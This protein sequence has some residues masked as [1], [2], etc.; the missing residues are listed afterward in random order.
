MFY[1]DFLF[2][3]RGP[4]AKV[5]QLSHLSKKLTRRDLAS[6]D[7][8]QSVQHIE[9]PSAPLALRAQGQLLLGLVRIYD[10]QVRFLQQDCTEAQTKLD[11]MAE[12]GGGRGRGVE[13]GAEQ[14]MASSA[15]ITVS[16]RAMLDGMDPFDALEEQRYLEQLNL[17]SSQQPLDA[18][19]LSQS[20][21]LSQS[22]S[23]RFSQQARPEDISMP[24]ELPRDRPSM[25]SQFDLEELQGEGMGMS[26]E[27]AMDDMGGVSGAGFGDIS[28][29]GAGME[30]EGAGMDLGLDDVKDISGMLDERKE[31][32]GE[33]RDAD[34]VGRPRVVLTEGD[35]RLMRER[36]ERRRER[37][38]LRFAV[39][40]RD[41]D[42]ELDDATMRA[43]IRDTADIVE[44]RAGKSLVD[45]RRRR[46]RLL[47]E[48]RFMH[49]SMAGPMRERSLDALMAELFSVEGLR[50]P[51]SEGARE[52]ERAA[53]AEDEYIDAQQLAGDDF[54]LDMS[55]AGA[56][57]L[58]PPATPNRAAADESM[59]G[60]EV[61]P[62]PASLSA[63]E[64]R[65]VERSEHEAAD[66]AHD[67][68]GEDDEYTEER[69]E[70]EVA[71]HGYSDRGR[72]VLQLLAERYRQPRTERVA[73]D[74]LLPGGGGAQQ[75]LAARMFYQ[76]L[77][78]SQHEAVQCEQAEM[79]GEIQVA[80]G[81]R[82]DE[83]SRRMGMP[84]GGR[85]AAKA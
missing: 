59:G 25:A 56:D 36:E 83:M 45:E 35:Q 41:E 22:Q 34:L 76:L 65:A 82:F 44:A 21:N 42:T 54:S 85:R 31:A 74:E 16:E 80:K 20:L 66:R 57:T 39:E 68:F 32:D 49:S 7:I 75:L 53:P 15:A 51:A 84:A 81:G 26:L 67:F 23:A 13:V 19:R 5:W 46:E 30:L 78:L 18:S 55:G 37:K 58:P 72:K 38:R 9:Q 64:L 50:L 33:I 1:A 60:G 6:T 10:G 17:S 14:L 24:L 47:A 29:T 2:V 43:A 4:L 48:G 77:V 12:R 70:Q 52:A 11:S 27:D 63:A 62:T 69:A 8:A 3:K 28:L 40:Q 79:Y 73:F 61:P 71:A